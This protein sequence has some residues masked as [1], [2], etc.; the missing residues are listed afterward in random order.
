M[1]PE[2]QL[3][4]NDML[5]DIARCL[6]LE[7]PEK[8]NVENCFWIAG[9]YWDKLQ[10]FILSAGF[11][12]EEDEMSF[13]RYVKPKFTCYI[14]YFSLLSEGLQF[15]P[16]WIEFPEQVKG[17]ID[18]DLWVRT[19]NKTV[20]E[21]WIKEEDRGNRFYNKNKVF[22]EYCESPCTEQDPE[23]FLPGTRVGTEFALIRSHNRDTDLYT[24]YEQILTTWEAYKLYS[25]FIN[26]RVNEL[27]VSSSGEKVGPT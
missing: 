14:E 12:N 25:E 4:H 21:Y 19:W 22:L 15:V 23:Y 9:N 7:H 26:K 27:V 2:Y 10:V 17:K 6:A 5:A 11:R 3:L 8:E 20:Q 18:E 1:K 16:P 13:Y 24:V